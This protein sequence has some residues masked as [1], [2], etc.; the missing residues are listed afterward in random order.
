M[1]DIVA[2]LRGL[3][4]PVTGECLSDFERINGFVRAAND[5]A[6]EIDRLRS[7]LVSDTHTILTKRPVAFR[8]R[9][10]NGWMILEDEAG[11]RMLAES[12]G[13]E[14]QGLYVRVTHPAIDT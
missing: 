13:V 9:Y 8:L 1:T 7:I 5:A 12:N 10:G 11:A 4:H 3:A 2:V 6:D 14:Y